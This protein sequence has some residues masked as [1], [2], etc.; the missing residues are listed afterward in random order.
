MMVVT[1]IEFNTPEQTRLC[2]VSTM[3]TSD[4]KCGYIVCDEIYRCEKQKKLMGRIVA[5]AVCGNS[6]RFLSFVCV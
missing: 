3:D 4:V 1:K 5:F 6:E 2:Q